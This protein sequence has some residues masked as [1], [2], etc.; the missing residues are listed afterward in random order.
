MLAITHPV[1]RILEVGLLVGLSACGG[2]PAS[3]CTELVEEHGRTKTEA[4]QVQIAD[5]CAQ[6]H[7]RSGDAKAGLEA[8]RA[9]LALGRLPA[10]IGWATTLEGTPVAGSAWAFAALAHERQG[11]QASDEDERTR[12]YDASIAAYERSL[13]AFEAQGAHRRAVAAA[14]GLLRRNWHGERMRPAMRAVDTALRHARRLGDPALEG[15]LAADVLVPLLEIGDIAAARWALARAGPHAVSEDVETQMML[16]LAEGTLRMAE[17]RPALARRAFER[18]IELAGETHD[19]KRARLARFNLIDVALEAGRVDEAAA[20]LAEIEATAGDRTAS[21]RLL[22]TTLRHHGGRIAAM[23][24]R[25]EQALTRFEAA[26]ADAPTDD[27]AWK[28]HHERAR[29][30]VTLS[31]RAEARGA[32]EASIEAVERMRRALASGSF[33][34]MLLESRRGP[35]EGLFTLEAEAGQV[36]AAVAVSE[37]ARARSFLD[38]FVT[39]GP[40]GEG[41]SGEGPSGEP[42]G[43][44][45]PSGEEPSGKPPS[46]EPSGTENPSGK[47]PS[48]DRPGGESPGAEPIEWDVARTLERADRIRALVERGESTADAQPQP[49]SGVLAGLGEAQVLA[50]FEADSRLWAITRRADALAL[51]RLPEPVEAIRARVDA[52]LGALDDPQLGRAVTSAIAPP[53]VLPPAD[54]NLYIVPDGVVSAVPFA[55]LPLADGPLVASRA[56]SLAPSL[57]VLAAILGRQEPPHPARPVV[58]GDARDDLPEARAEAE[59]VAEALG[60]RAQLGPAATLGALAGARE[61]SLL[62]VATH[63][64]I[65]ERGAWIDLAD[66]RVH[67]FDLAVGTEAPTRVVLAS[68]AS[69]ARRGRGLWGS[70]GSAFIAAG[71][72]SVVASLWSVHD[73]PARRFVEQFYAKGGALHPG[74]AL[75]ATQRSFSAAGEP[76]STWSAFVM[77]GAFEE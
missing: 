54:T 77:I 50:Y 42:S 28:L 56:T 60:A 14:R 43:T 3:R 6:A 63:G 26:L 62:H 13:T 19:G 27:W 55:A 70:V 18:V 7:A 30:L 29:V 5:V 49:L 45:H 15:R 33:K 46:G 24:G 31:R 71:S 44:E 58:L 32:F 65:D 36:R 66:G 8:S 11:E 75:A 2:D 61:A 21:D 57:G 69:A 10:V 52:W 41:P 59:H 12:H 35:Y 1:A 4:L 64:G 76:S 51:H 37:R 48:G 73:Q 74:R 47:G 72:T 23:Q 17:G 22:R 67:A 68:C 16:S 25:P 34:H 39:E 40:S 38:A 20:L 9:Q 53:E